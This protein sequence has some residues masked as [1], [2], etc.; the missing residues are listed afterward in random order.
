MDAEPFLISTLPTGPYGP[1]KAFAGQ[2]KHPFA[3][4]EGTTDVSY[5]IVTF[6]PV[7]AVFCALA[8]L[9]SS[10]VA[11]LPRLVEGAIAAVR[12]HAAIVPFPLRR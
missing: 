4:R 7:P 1:V 12:F 8:I 6:Q 9:A 2:S 10:V 5:V 3:P 11:V